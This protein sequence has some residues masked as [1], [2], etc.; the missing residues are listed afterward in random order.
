MSVDPS[1]FKVSKEINRTDI[2]LCV[3][4]VPNSDRL[5]AGSSDSHIHEIDLSDEKKESAPPRLEGHGSYVTGLA[6]SGNHLIS[7][8]YDGRLIWW[9]LETRDKT[10]MVKAHDRWIRDVVVSPDGEL[11]ASVADDMVCKLWDVDTGELKREMHGHEAL[12]VQ[13]FSSMLYVCAFSAD[14]RHLATA[15]RVGHIVVWNVASGQS[16][17]TMEA[18]ELYTWDGRQRIR[19]IGGVRSLAFSPDGTLLAAGGVGQI[20][21]VDGLGG[22]ARVEVFDWQKRERVVEFA[23]EK[24]K[25]LIEHLE[26]H[27]S[28]EWLLGAGGDSKGS[29]IAFDVNAKKIIHEETAA[30]H[31]HDFVMN[32]RYDRFYAAGHQKFAVFEAPADVKSDATPTDKTEKAAKVGMESPR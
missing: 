5:F 28:G 27:P 14:G 17:A 3:A 32:E 26:F 16:V 18:P 13:H 29:V 10:R 21:N 4:R 7:S 2:L 20:Q 19:S 25:G 22:K 30:M 31:I 9:N 24:V 11:A 6:L 23:A 8:G 1:K 15:D 12:T